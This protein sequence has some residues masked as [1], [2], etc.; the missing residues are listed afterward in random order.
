MDFADLQPLIQMIAEQEERIV[1]HLRENNK[2][3]NEKLMEIKDD[4]R[5]V[6]DHVKETN[7]KVAEHVKEIHELK[8]VD[9]EIKS[10]IDKGD[11]YCHYVQDSKTRNARRN[12]WIITTL[13]A[14]LALLSGTLYKNRQ[15]KMVS[16]EL[17]YQ[18]TDSTFV[19]PRMYLRQE[20]TNGYS[21]VHELYIDIEETIKK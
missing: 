12:K 15:D 9:N 20:G 13:I 10:M 7:G 11:N 17:I 1:G 18:K 8:L 14:L 21:E 5:E 3:I 2:N 16:L 6:K 19:I 4:V